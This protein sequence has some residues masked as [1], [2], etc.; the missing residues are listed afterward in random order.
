MAWIELHQSLIRHPKVIRVSEALGVSRLTIVGH[1]AALWCW[2]LD[3][4]PDG[5]PLTD[6]DVRTGAEWVGRKDFTAALTDARF[7]DAG[8]DGLWLHNWPIYTGKL[9]D[10]RE[11]RKQSNREAQTRRRERL[12]ASSQRVV[13]ADF[14]DS[15]HST[16]PNPTQQNRTEPDPETEGSPLP[17]IDP[18]TRAEAR[19][20]Y[21]AMSSELGLHGVPAGWAES[22]LQTCKP[23]LIIHAIG[24][25]KERGKRSRAYVDGILNDPTFE[26]P[27][28]HQRASGNGSAPPDPEPRPLTAGEIAEYEA[29]A[30]WQREHPNRQIAVLEGALARERQ[31]R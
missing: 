11:L 20:V 26:L 13:S 29:A 4:K 6:L 31:S 14:D 17:P 27:R 25:A 8:V 3:A 28:Q 7:I 12:S 22:W 15:Q 19:T 30:A 9:R 2:A 18:E 1:M 10:Q 23:A 16:Q 5:G 24:I 21:D